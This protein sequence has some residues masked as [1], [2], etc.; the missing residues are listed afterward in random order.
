V[1]CSGSLNARLAQH[2]AGRGAR[3]LEVVTAAGIGFTLARTWEG[4]RYRERQL[5]RQGGAAALCPICRAAGRR[6]HRP[7]RPGRG[8][9]RQL[10]LPLHLR[11]HRTPARMPARR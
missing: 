6:R 4:S 11:P 10:V 9:A 3:L 1:A 7:P 8:G 5:K 2:R